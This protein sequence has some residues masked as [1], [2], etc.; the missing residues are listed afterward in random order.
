MAGW[1]GEAT[2]PRIIFHSE[3]GQNKE[4]D[5]EETLCPVYSSSKHPFASILL[6]HLDKAEKL[7][8][9]IK[10]NEH[11]NPFVKLLFVKLLFVKLLGGGGFILLQA[12][13][14]SKIYMT[15]SLF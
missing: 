15:G 1:G 7:P 14:A 3:F 4:T 5:I 10:G 12:V 9:E 2:T 8:Q 13:C 11:G 6:A